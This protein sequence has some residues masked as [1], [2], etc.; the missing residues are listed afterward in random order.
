MLGVALIFNNTLRQYPV[1][2]W[3]P[4]EVGYG[5]PWNLRKAGEG[6]VEG[7]L[8]KAKTAHTPSSGRSLTEVESNGTEFVE[9]I[10]GVH[11]TPYKIK[12]PQHI[13]LSE[14]EMELLQ[15]LQERIREHSEVN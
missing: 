13:H 7:D 6:D 10:D 9:R 3:T 12:L 15:H 8:E 1:F 2:W 5:L 4:E 14:G 11:V